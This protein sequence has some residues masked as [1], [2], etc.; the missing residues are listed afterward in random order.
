MNSEKRKQTICLTP[1]IFRK[2]EQKNDLQTDVLYE[3]V[4]MFFARIQFTGRPEKHS[5]TQSGL[6]EFTALIVSRLQLYIAT[7][8]TE[9]RFSV[10]F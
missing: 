4:K 6:E 2:C 9:G 7:G 3:L 1:K 10:Y 8:Q 5:M